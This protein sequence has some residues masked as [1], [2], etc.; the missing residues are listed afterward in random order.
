MN[1]LKDINWDGHT[2][3]YSLLMINDV[4]RN[5]FYQKALGNVQGK[6]VLDIGSGTG[7]LSV[8]AVM[9]GARKVYSFER[10]VGNYTIAKQF[11]SQSGME[12]RIELICS[13]ILEVDQTVWPHE[14]IDVIVTET[15]AN[16]CFIENFPFL[17]E[18]VEKHFNLAENHQWIPEKIDLNLDLIDIVQKDEFLPGVELPNQYQAQ[19]Q[20][21]IQ[22]YRDHF[23]HKHSYDQKEQ[24]I[25]MP[26]AQI[27][28]TDL[29]RLTLVDTY[30]VDGNLRSTL[31]NCR[32]NLNFD[33]T[34]VKNPYI[35]V[36]WVLHYKEQNIKMNQVVSWRNI[37]F[38]INPDL[39]SAFY[40]RFNPFTYSLIGSQK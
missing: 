22:I 20:E 13:D 9:Q 18:H 3:G 21:A 31:S 1:T 8:L 38:K 39:G 40:F 33:H 32:Y 5:Q 23:Y 15:F 4:D 25:N 17:V 34:Q 35:K 7:L 27:P 37:A 29:D 19:I 10:N 36:D 14:P 16:D 6:V 26:V 24:P 12:D 28:P 2:F 11:I 30:H